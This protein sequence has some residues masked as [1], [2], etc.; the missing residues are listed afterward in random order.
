MRVSVFPC[1]NLFGLFLEFEASC[2]EMRVMSRTGRGSGIGRVGD[3]SQQAS[4]VRQTGLCG[5]Q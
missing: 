1:V 4:E 3:I 2:N 5:H